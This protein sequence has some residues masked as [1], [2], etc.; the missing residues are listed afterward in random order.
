MFAQPLG[1][2]PSAC[3]RA[4]G[5]R[6]L[7]AH[8]Y[9]SHAHCGTLLAVPPSAADVPSPL[10]SRPTFSKRTQREASSAALPEVPESA[11]CHMREGG[12]PQDK[13]AGG[14]SS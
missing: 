5:K 4:K 2:C 3:A 1:A 9:V 11:S 10:L 14:E 8:A 7:H 12:S 13:S 6:V